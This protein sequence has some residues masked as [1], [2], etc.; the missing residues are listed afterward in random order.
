KLIEE[1]GILWSTKD[2]LNALLR[3]SGLRELPEVD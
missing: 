1:N 2:D 3:Y